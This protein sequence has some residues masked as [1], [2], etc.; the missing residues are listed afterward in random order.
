MHY[1]RRIIILKRKVEKVEKDKGN[2]VLENIASVQKTISRVVP[3][4]EV[5]SGYNAPRLEV[6]QIHRSC[7]EEVLGIPLW[8]V[9]GDPF[10]T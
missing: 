3:E 8:M 10:A 6:L 5:G 1:G 2:E 7:W 4:I 9:F